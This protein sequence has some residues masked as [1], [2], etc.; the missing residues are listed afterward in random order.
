MAATVPVPAPGAGGGK[1]SAASRGGDTGS[2]A[3]GCEATRARG[4]G[5]LGQIVPL[6]TA[7]SAETNQKGLEW[8]RM[9]FSGGKSGHAATRCPALDESFPFMLSGWRAESTPGVSL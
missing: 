5:Q 1:I 2:P 9:F 6:G 8:C 4:V 3:G 7:D